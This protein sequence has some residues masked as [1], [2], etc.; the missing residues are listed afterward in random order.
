MADDYGI[1]DVAETDLP[2]NSI[3]S[4]IAERNGEDKDGRVYTI[5]VTVYDAGELSDSGSVDVIVPH[6]Q[7]KK[8]AKN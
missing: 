4:L 2:E 1:Y 8:K 5:T 3:I 6:D 7:G